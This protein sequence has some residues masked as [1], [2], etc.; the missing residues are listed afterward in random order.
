MI[1][2]LNNTTIAMISRNA[3]L[4]LYRKTVRKFLYSHPC[5]KLNLW[6]AYPP[7]DGIYVCVV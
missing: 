1:E 6:K 7:S 4:L 2:V 5:K 3:R